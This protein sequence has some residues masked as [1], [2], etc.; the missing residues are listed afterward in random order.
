MKHFHGISVRQSKEPGRTPPCRVFVYPS[1]KE[2][3]LSDSHALPVIEIRSDRLQGNAG[4]KMDLKKT[5][6]K[7]HNGV[8]TVLYK[9]NTL[10]Q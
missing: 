7:M 9:F 10:K 3:V 5:V 2:V 1:A 6:D 8:Y 4:R